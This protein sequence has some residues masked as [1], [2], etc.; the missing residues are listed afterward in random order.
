MVTMNARR[1]ALFFSMICGMSGASAQLG[2]ESVDKAAKLEPGQS[3]FSGNTKIT[4]NQRDAG[5]KDADGWFLVK[6]AKDGFS[7]RFPAPITDETHYIRGGNGAS[8]EQ[9]N[10]SARTSTMNFV[11][12]CTKDRNHR[13]S[14]DTV[15]QVV[16]AIAGLSHQFASA[17]FKNGALVGTEYSG[18][19]PKGT[20]FAGQSFMLGEQFCQF[21]VGSREPFNGIP[22]QARTAFDSFR[23]E[24]VRQ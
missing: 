15:H 20:Y 18:I 11:V 2:P 23:P 4:L 17:P 19:D 14:A 5:T 6:S 21:L 10:L 9:N 12:G 7:V 13:I 3:V 22:A 16:T 1:V 8:I 24:D